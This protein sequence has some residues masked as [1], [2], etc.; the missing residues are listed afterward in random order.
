MEKKW[1]E[2]HKPMIGNKTTRNGFKSCS[3]RNWGFCSQCCCAV[4]V[5]NPNDPSDSYKSSKALQANPQAE[6]CIAVPCLV[7]TVT[8]SCLLSKR[9]KG[10]GCGHKEG[11][12]AQT[13]RV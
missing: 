4:V 8:K 5:G 2:Q 11:N 10:K 12:K 3:S 6:T 1:Q 9:K 13:A 7:A